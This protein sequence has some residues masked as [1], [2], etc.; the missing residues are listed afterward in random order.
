M[1][2][3]VRGEDMGKVLKVNQS[4]GTSWLNFM[5]VANVTEVA[6]ID[7]RACLSQGWT[8]RNR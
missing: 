3:G 8:A 5:D 4:L 6:A 2:G 1:I 7:Q